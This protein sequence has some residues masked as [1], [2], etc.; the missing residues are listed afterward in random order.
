MNYP[1]ETDKWKTLCFVG[2]EADRKGNKNKKQ[3]EG[4]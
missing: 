2:R 1:S 3:K 4:L